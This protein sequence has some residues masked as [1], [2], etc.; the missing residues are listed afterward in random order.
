MAGSQYTALISQP[1]YR[2]ITLSSSSS[3]C[4]NSRLQPACRLLLSPLTQP[5]SHTHRPQSPTPIL[6]Q[7]LCSCQ[8][9]L[10]GALRLE[11]GIHTYSMGSQPTLQGF[12]SHVLGSHHKEW[13]LCTISSE[14]QPKRH[15]L[16]LRLPMRTLQDGLRPHSRLQLHSCRLLCR[17]FKAPGLQCSQLSR[18]GVHQRNKQLRSLLSKHCTMQRQPL[19]LRPA[20]HRAPTQQH[21]SKQSATRPPEHHGNQ[22]QALQPP[23]P[24][25]GA[26][27]AVQSPAT[28]VFHHCVS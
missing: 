16:S 27:A 2:E 10:P 7:C 20:M 23:L 11:V 4:N 21:A 5:S 9:C 24:Q 1:L 19:P 15:T 26:P 6:M 17:C 25:M 12:P 14:Q 8:A 18:L 3:I 13:Q 22:P 28:Q